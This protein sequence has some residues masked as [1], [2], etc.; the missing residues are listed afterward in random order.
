MFSFVNKLGA[1]LKYKIYYL[2]YLFRSNSKLKIL[3]NSVFLLTNVSRF[4][5]YDYSVHK[6]FMN[7]RIITLIE[8]VFHI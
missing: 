6:I 1:L 7:R 5:Q 4:F 8:K 3:I 2:F